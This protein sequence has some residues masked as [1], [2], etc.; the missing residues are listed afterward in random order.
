M[1]VAEVLKVVLEDLPGM[2]SMIKEELVEMMAEC[3]WTL[4][5]ELETSQPMTREITF[6]QLR[7]CGAPEF[8]R[9]KELIVCMQWIIDIEIDFL[10]RF[11]PNGEKA[12]L[13]VRLLREGM[14]D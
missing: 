1:I 8:F 7:V 9:K 14:R 4:Q 5:D 10:R 6:W 3:L 12:K 2:L 13:D 11:F